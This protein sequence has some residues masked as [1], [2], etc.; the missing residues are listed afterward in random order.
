M[1]VDIVDIIGRESGGRNVVGRPQSLPQFYSATTVRPAA[2]EVWWRYEG[3]TA[4]AARLIGTYLPGQRVSFPYTP[5]GDKNLIL[6]TISISAAGVRSVRDIRDAPEF[7]VVF[8]RETDAPTVTQVGT[9]THTL[10]TLAI[11]GFSALAYRRKVRTA[12]DSAMTTNESEEIIEVAPGAVL[13]RLL[14]LTRPDPGAGTRTIY[15]RISHS[16]GGDFG[17]ESA[18]AAFTWADDGGAGG[19][20]GT[21]DPI[22]GGGATCFSGNVRIRTPAGL[23]SFSD[24]RAVKSP[25]PIVNQTGTHGAALIIHERYD[26]PM[27]DMGGGELVTP[28]HLMKQYDPWTTFASWLPAA[29][30]F[31]GSP[32]VRFT[33][34]VFNLHILSDDPDDQ[35]YLLANGEI[36][37]NFKPEG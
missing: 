30:R 11:D 33:G 36:A 6:S 31:P 35:H 13:P 19:G 23:Q 25:F 21:G 17:S 34:D 4:A 7:L 8:Q 26:G 15:V 28:E 5:I 10:I 18:A 14:Y 37:H 27:I 24:L 16:S 20:S 2:V 12:D 22:G 9:A 29:S 1:S 3:E 32:R